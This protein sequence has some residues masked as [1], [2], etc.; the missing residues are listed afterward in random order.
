MKSDT[1]MLYERAHGVEI[2]TRHLYTARMGSTSDLSAEK[3]I[4]F[5]L[6]TRLRVM[7]HFDPPL[8]Y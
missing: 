1:V 3:V 8:T 4:D 7:C 5:H 2:A 6:E